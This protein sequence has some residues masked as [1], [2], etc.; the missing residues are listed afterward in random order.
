MGLF[1][2]DEQPEYED[3]CRIKRNREDVLRAIHT[4]VKSDQYNDTIKIEMIS[5]I[6]ED[7]VPKEIFE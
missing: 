6:L 2:F 5:G 7:F 1:S 3:L 4:V